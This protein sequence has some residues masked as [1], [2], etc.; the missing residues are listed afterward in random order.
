MGQV[1]FLRKQKSRANGSGQK[2]GVLL[3]PLPAFP[4]QCVSRF[5]LWL[6]LGEVLVPS[7]LARC[8]P[9]VCS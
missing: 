8:I 3:S 5:G 6:V 4:R 2:S 9:D 7:P 1:R